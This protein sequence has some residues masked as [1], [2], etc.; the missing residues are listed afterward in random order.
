MHIILESFQKYLRL[1]LYHLLL[2]NENFLNEYKRPIQ[3]PS[4]LGLVV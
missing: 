2:L 3:N 1:A 4:L